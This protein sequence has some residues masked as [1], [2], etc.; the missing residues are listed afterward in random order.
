MLSK[1]V[2]ILGNLLIYIL[3]GILLLWLCYMFTMAAINTVCDCTLE[4]EQKEGA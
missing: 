3:A 4:L 1:A 2:E